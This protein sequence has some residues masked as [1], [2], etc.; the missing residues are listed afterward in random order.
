MIGQLLQMLHRDERGIVFII[1][2][3]VLVIVLIIVFAMCG[4]GQDG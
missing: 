2:I 3:V 4:D 1:P